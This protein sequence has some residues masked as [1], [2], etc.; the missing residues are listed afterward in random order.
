MLNSKQLIRAFYFIF[1]LMLLSCCKKSNYDIKKVS[2]EMNAPII[3]FENIYHQKIFMLLDTGA[4]TNVVDSV[5]FETYFNCLPF[6]SVRIGTIDKKN[7]INSPIYS[8][9]SEDKIF[10]VHNLKKVMPLYDGIVGGNYLRNKIVYLNYKKGI[11]KFLTNQQFAAKSFEDSV[12]FTLINNK[13]YIYSSLSIND[14]IFVNGNFLIDTGFSGGIRILEF[15]ADSIQIDKVPCKKYRLKRKNSNMI[16]DDKGVLL[17]GKD[18]CFGNQKVIGPIIYYSRSE[19]N[20][21]L[22]EKKMKGVIGNDFLKN[23]EIIIHY[24]NNEIYFNTYKIKNNLSFY[25]SGITLGREHQNGFVIAGLIENSP[26][27]TRGIRI[28]DILLSIEQLKATKENFSK[29]VKL[30]R[31]P[32]FYKLKLKR[33][34][35]IF[36]KQVPVK[37]L[38]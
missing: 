20:N 33:N 12:N 2:K 13:P 23:F 36:E 35:S 28:G 5:Y 25:R 30:L 9:G 24:K 1:F 14:T 3:S 16:T 15:V 31:T 38:L 21:S 29:I 37:K 10:I 34:D 11:I 27:D 26:A 18:L 4:P 17:K 8:C 6:D 22:Y 7:T 32:G 19:K